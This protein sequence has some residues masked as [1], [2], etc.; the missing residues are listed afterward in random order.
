MSN[1][2]KGIKRFQHPTY[3]ESQWQTL[4]PYLLKGEA[5]FVIDAQSKTI[6]FKA[7]PGYWND[8]DFIGEGFYP[9]TDLVT[10]PIGDLTVGSSQEGRSLSA[11]IKDMI[12]PYA[13]AAVSGLQNNADGGY[14]V[15]AVIEVGNSVSG[16]V[17]LSF[18]VTNQENLYSGGDNLN[19]A[20]GGIFN[21]EGWSVYSTGSVPLTLISPLAPGYN[22]TFNINVK[23]KHEQGESSVVTTAISF[24]PRIIWGNSPLPSLTGVEFAAIGNYNQVISNSYQRDYAFS[25]VNYHYIG[26]PVMLNPT[27]LVFTDVT[28][29]NQPAGIG[30]ED[31]GVLNVPNGVGTYDYRIYRTTFDLLSSVIIRIA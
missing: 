3:T 9:F 25:G 10:N 11:I 13:P 28:D 18:V 7:G 19:I 12:S 15:T 22:Q 14:K 2:L 16:T 20:A 4:N 30:I 17:T 23:V 27:G 8:L 1:V 26:I 24:R 29:P 6:S 21:E 31:L 5:G